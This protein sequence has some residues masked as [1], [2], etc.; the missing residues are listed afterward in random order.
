MFERLKRAF[1][2][3]ADAVRR[4]TGTAKKLEAET[5]HVNVSPLPAPRYFLP[6]SAFTKRGP[7]V[8]VRL[9]LALREMPVWRRL[10]CR[11]K[12]WDRG[13]VNRDGSMVVKP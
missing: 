5:S 12:G 6:R 13:M 10:Q 1:G 3:A 11:A 2:Y 7:G 4:F 9:W 8:K